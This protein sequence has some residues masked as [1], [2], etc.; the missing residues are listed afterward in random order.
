MQN[1]ADSV[2]EP[3]KFSFFRLTGGIF[4]FKHRK[5]D[6]S[7]VGRGGKKTAPDIKIS[8]AEREAVFKCRRP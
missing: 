7:A 1:A 2:R 5:E 4:L 6:G 3:G 8:D